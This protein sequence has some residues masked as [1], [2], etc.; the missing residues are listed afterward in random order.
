M[1]IADMARA[2]NSADIVTAAIIA[3]AVM[4]TGSS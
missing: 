4:V 3:D 2:P 1:A